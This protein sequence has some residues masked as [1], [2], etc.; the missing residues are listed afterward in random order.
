MTTDS[1]KSMKKILTM[2]T[3]LTLLIT[4]NV[5]AGK[6][7]VVKEETNPPAAEQALTPDQ[8][9][10]LMMMDQA[11]AAPSASANAAQDSTMLDQS[12]QQTS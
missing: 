3:C 2:M 7:S 12:T 6:D 8:I 11:A 10:P 5:L 9:T 4:Q 1:G